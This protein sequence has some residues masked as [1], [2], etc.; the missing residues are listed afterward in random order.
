MKRIVSYTVL[1]GFL[2]V[3]ALPVFVQSNEKAQLIK[4]RE[5][6]EKEI[7]LTNR[8][9]NDTRNKKENSLH[10]YKLVQ[11][12]I[13]SRNKLIKKLNEDIEN[14]ELE[15][16]ENTNKLIILKGE[17]EKSKNEYFFLELPGN[18]MAFLDSV[19]GRWSPVG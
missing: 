1:I 4:K 8:L 2:L 5:E 6:I 16:Q 3:I 12:K 17:L 14:T 18:I 19:I 9:L 13:S 7:A 15:I 11:T 10:E